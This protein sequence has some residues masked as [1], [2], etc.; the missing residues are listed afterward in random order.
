MVGGRL[1]QYTNALDFD[2][3]AEGQAASREGAASWIRGL[4]VAAVDIVHCWPVFDVGEIDC[5]LR[6]MGHVGAIALENS[7]NIFQHLFG[8]RADATFDKC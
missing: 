1:A 5:A 6:H 8:L 7:L 4:E 2:S 3:G